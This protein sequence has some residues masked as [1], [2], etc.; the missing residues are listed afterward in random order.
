MAYSEAQIR[1]AI[2]RA[3][4]IAKREYQQ[5]KIKEMGGGR[6][7]F[8]QE[9][10]SE[11]INEGISDLLEDVLAEKLLP[12]A[13]II[14]TMREVRKKYIEEKMK[15]GILSQALVHLGTV[16]HSHV[17]FEK[18]D[19]E[20]SWKK[21]QK[22]LDRRNQKEIV[23]GLNHLLICAI[24]DLTDTELPPMPPKYEIPAE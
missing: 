15:L 22:G 14:I 18:V 11:L 24:N 1:E 3:E 8:L 13:R 9:K 16:T 19:E 7:T 10:T 2:I 21:F 6:L 5:R 4:T 17:T 12:Q 20:E 23:S